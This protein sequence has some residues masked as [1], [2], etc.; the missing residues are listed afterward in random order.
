MQSV[1]KLIPVLFCPLLFFFGMESLRAQAFYGGVLTGGT[2]YQGDLQDKGFNSRDIRVFGG[3]SVHY[4]TKRFLSFTA[5]LTIGHLSGRDRFQNKS[6]NLSFNTSLYELGFYGRANLLNLRRLPIVPYV[7]TGFTVFHVNPYTTD[8]SGSRVELY[9]LRLEGQGLN[10]YQE[11]KMQRKVN[12]AVPIS[13]GLEFMVTERLRVDMEV[14]LRKT[15][16]DY[17][18]DVSHNYPDYDLLL[19]YTGPKAVELSYRGDELPDGSPLFPSGLQR[20]GPNSDW[21][22]SF[23]IRVR[24]PIRIWTHSQKFEYYIFRKG[25]WPYH[26]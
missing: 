25:G 8:A 10:A 6:R 9:P 21:Y 26:W 16:T 13:G 19:N 2:N 7:A 5:D 20:G 11:R 14:T 24:Y 4:E 1:K 23:T 15:F 12:I 17:I 3:A 18:D 22:N